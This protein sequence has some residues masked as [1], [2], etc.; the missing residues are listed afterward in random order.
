M[1]TFDAAQVQSWFTRYLADFVDLPESAVTLDTTFAK[2]GFDSVDSVIIS[3]AFEE[4][5]DV[6]VDATLF[7]RNDDLRSLIEDLRA[8]GLIA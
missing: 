2:L 5:F 7:L 4:A 8:S 1:K 6:E 3:G